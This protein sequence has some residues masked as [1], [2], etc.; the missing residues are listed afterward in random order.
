MTLSTSLVA[1]AEP[2]DTRMADDPAAP[3]MYDDTRS[4]AD[5]FSRLMSPG[6]TEATEAIESTQALE[7]G[8][9][10]DMVLGK[11]NAMGEHYRNVKGAVSHT[12]ENL[13]P[14]MHLPDIFLLQMEMATASLVVEVVSKGVSKVVQHVDQL[15]K[16][17]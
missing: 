13:S 3:L 17:Q 4:A 2:L 16:L 10:G 8:N 15:T 14:S 12:L 6:E 5:R 11:L 7:G 1:L 9:L